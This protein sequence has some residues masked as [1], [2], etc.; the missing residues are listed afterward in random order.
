MSKGLKAKAIKAINQQG[1]LLVYPINNRKD[2]KSLWS[3]LFPKS[4]MVWEWTDE[5]DNRVAD[6]WHL[7]AELSTSRQVIYSKWF[8]GR[9]TFFSLEIFQA[10]YCLTRD[11]KPKNWTR[12]S[13]VILENLTMDSPQSTKQLKASVDLQGK[14]LERVYEK[15]MRP[16]WQHLDIVAF[17]EIED[18]S[19]PSLA[20][21]ATETLFED[22]VLDSKNMSRTKALKLVTEQMKKSIAVS[23]FVEGLGFIEPSTVVNHP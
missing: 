22:L 10:L 4:K 5:S 14:M 3:E 7:R 9:A 8:R 15:A 2:P 6:L 21:G 11:W 19:F 13:T 17:G 18:S 12:E 23:K 20:T 1:I 16:L